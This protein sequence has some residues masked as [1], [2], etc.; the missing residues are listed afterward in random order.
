MRRWLISG[1]LVVAAL[2]LV[3]RV[4]ADSYVDY[5]WFSS[6]GASERWSVQF[7]S[8][9]L[10]TGASAALAIAFLFAN[11][12]TVRRSIVSLVLP[13]RLGNIEIGEEVPGKYLTQVAFA[14]A[15]L[16]GLL[17]SF[18]RDGWMLFATARYA[19]P[20]LER[21]SVFEY[22]LSYFVNWL[23][24]EQ[25]LFTWCLILL[26]AAALLVVFLYILTSSLKWERGHG[27]RATLYVRR[28]IGAIGAI[29]LLVLAWSFRLEMFD[30]LL[31]GSGIEG[32][33]TAADRQMINARTALSFVTM[34]VAFL[35]AWALWTD[36][37]R[38]AFLCLTFVL[39]AAL[40][41]RGLY[42]LIVR[43]ST[44]QAD[45]A[46][47]ERGYAAIR[48]GRTRR[49]FDVD[50]ISPA[51]PAG[52]FFFPDMQAATAGT[53][54]WD[55]TE[56]GTAATRGS[57]NGIPQGNPAYRIENGTQRIEAVIGPRTVAA[58]AVL[59]LTLVRGSSS[60]V[61]PDEVWR[62]ANDAIV[63][64]SDAV[65]TEPGAAL[66]VVADP[67][68][69][70]M[71][72][73]MTSVLTRVAHAWSRQDFRL[74]FSDLPEP[75]P[76]IVLHAGV[77]ERIRRVAPFFEQ[78]GAVTPIFDG[79]T[80]LWALPLYSHSDT[81]PL[82]HPVTIAGKKHRY[83][84]HAATAIVNAS[85]GGI[86]I[87]PI[88]EPDA[89]T[90]TWMNA[91]PSL[92][93]NGRELR[94]SVADQLPPVVDGAMAQAAAY[95]LYSTRQDS[96]VGGALA[97]FADDTVE[98]TPHRSL[99]HLPDL[100]PNAT[101]IEPVLDANDR[102][103]RLLLAVGG[104]SP[105]TYSLS[106]TPTT[107]WRDLTRRFDL[108]TDSIAAR[109]EGDVSAGPIRAI[110]VANDIAY[111]RTTYLLSRSGEPTI[112][113]VSIMQRDSL[114]TA[115]SLHL[116]AQVKPAGQDDIVLTPAQFRSRV[117]QL[118]EQMQ[119][120]LRAGDL[121]A[122]GRAFDALGALLSRSSR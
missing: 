53:P 30:S 9:M 70:V 58:G 90:R 44:P 86:S 76:T 50:A 1:L 97:Y 18:P 67:F 80:L 71:A 37:V 77:R 54:A 27:F 73:R 14:V 4:A 22:D 115:S 103:H 11:L 17:I 95:A 2:L 40:T 55:P 109:E 112:A 114:R 121:Q 104:S 6:L 89:L 84:H 57:D 41:T 13:R 3:G 48:A 74:L 81:Y 117:A 88:S 59:S 32:A 45:Q 122:F 12:F 87:F 26:I 52:M 105:R 120:A 20:F 111:V 99:V 68:E 15:V 38:L 75:S 116:A 92:F 78:D 51:E 43:E 69:R 119:A 100:A 8:Q 29:A 91:M 19:E 102:V 60:E 5:L 106:F 118:H 33:F 107:G 25:A 94:A 49:A 66:L 85:T 39:V 35:F 10:L 36:Q 16:V 98:N 46:D 56:F 28:H 62:S 113:A 64:M 93:A 61:L 65:I 47:N 63:Q 7:G 96:V 24:F 83:F 34:L 72:P 23:P 101:W 42:P 108:V 110:P 21:D 79:D 82:S 31:N